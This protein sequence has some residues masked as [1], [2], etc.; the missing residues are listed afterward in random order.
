MTS[1]QPTKN[2]LAT[3]QQTTNNKQQTTNNKQQTTNN[4]QM[5][6]IPPKFRARI[7]QAKEQGL[8]ELDLSNDYYASDR[9]KLKEIP[10]E[11]FELEQLEVLNL[12]RNQITNLPES[13]GQLSNLTRLYLSVNQITNLPESIGQLSNLTRLYLSIN[14]ITN[15]PESIGQLS[16]LTWLYLNEN[17]ITNLPESIGQL[18]NL[19]RLYLS[20]N[21][22]TNLPESIGQLS[23]LTQLDFS[24]NQITNLPE[25][26]GQL[27]NL[28]QLDL[29]EN[30]ITN[31]PESIGQLSNLTELDLS[32]NLITNLPES[33]GQLSNLSQLD[34]SENQITTLPES[35][36]QLSNLTELDLSEN[37]IT[38]LPESIAK[39]SH[40]RPNLW[41]NPLETP[42]IEIAALGMAATGDYFAQ[43]KPDSDYLYEAKLLIVGE[44]GAGKT[45]LAKKIQNPDYELQQEDSTRGIDVI[46]WYFSYKNQQDFRMNIWDFGG[47]EIYHATH[48]FFLTK[49]S[50]YTLVVDTRK[51]D[52]DFDYWLNIVELLSDKSPLLIIKNEKQ[53]R[54][55]DI[56]E[57]GLRGQ[58]T[59]LEK[60][61]ATNL[62]TNRGL[63]D[64]LTQVKHS[65]TTLPHVRNKLPKTWKQVR[66][67][68]EQDGRN[69][70]RLREYLQICQ[71]NGITKREYKLQLS[72]YL[73]DLG[74]CLHFQDDL[75]LNRTLRLR[76]GQAVIL[77][78]EWVTAAVYKVLDNHRLRDNWGK[79]T[80]QDLANIWQGKK[81]KNAQAELLQLMIKF[82]LCYQI[83]N[84]KETYIAPQLL[85]ENQPEYTL[86]E[87]NNLILRYTY[88]FMPKGIITQFIVA[89]HK[90][91]W[92]QQYVWKS[93]V[94][95][96][97]DETFAE[98][99]EYYGKR[100][101]KIRVVGKYKRD[102]LIAVTHEL[103]KINNSYEQ[104]K[105]NKLIPCNCEQC[106]NN[107]DPHFYKYNKLKERIAYNQLE[108][109]CDNPPYNTVQ[110]LSL[111]DDPIELLSQLQNA[112]V[113]ETSLEDK[114][115]SDASEEVQNLKEGAQNPDE[116]KKKIAK[117]IKGLKIIF[118]SLPTVTKTATEVVKN[119]DKL[120][121]AISKLLLGS[122]G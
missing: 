47:Q 67:V 29:S 77:K 12:R 2:K 36:G 117:A 18:S 71:D 8:K 1:T 58:F 95:L 14:Q 56:N 33:I 70:I 34:L 48:Q 89:M 31:L 21:L 98:V 90:Y 63:A 6:E 107:Q 93:G 38:N 23:N 114:D 26:I 44:G 55:K 79:F 121:E 91:I 53:D 3:V 65:I 37:Q 78:P 40:L 116:G 100:E 16:N 41:G 101:I 80:K 86:E 122:G 118:T 51:E 111:I 49:R 11:V 42:P 115:K 64:I 68:L 7:E 24:R 50:L 84:T 10:P 106:Q 119:F 110:V 28:T 83:P 74:V 82:K 113:D 27:S 22:I 66:E 99:I 45:T 4:K 9:D 108:I 39:L 92:Q 25:S 30:E 15:L 46:T 75:L 43:L 88:E 96:E 60:T 97:K 52:T 17:Q 112:I 73:H 104:L 54:K 81:Y 61:L 103:D 57:R 19:T 76:S 109:Q 5:T 35:I 85:T 105:Y 102:L 59:N 69:Y 32:W 13:I 94:I 20:E 120:L 87:T 72:G 62:K